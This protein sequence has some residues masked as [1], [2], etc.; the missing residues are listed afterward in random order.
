MKQTHKLSHHHQTLLDS[1]TPTLKLS[2]IQ[3]IVDVGHYNLSD[4]MVS[5]TEAL[6]DQ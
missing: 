2:V 3:L 4:D 1:S 5:E 6:I